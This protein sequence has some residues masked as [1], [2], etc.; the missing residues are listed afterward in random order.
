MRVIDM[1]E[2]SR[3]ALAAKTKWPEVS[4]VY[5]RSYSDDNQESI[6]DLRTRKAEKEEM[7]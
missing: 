2:R 1:S 7:T 5:T 6:S 3:T 4:C